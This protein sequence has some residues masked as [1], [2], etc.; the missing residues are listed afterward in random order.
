MKRPAY[1]VKTK[2]SKKT[3]Q[4]GTRKKVKSP[5]QK[6]PS[7]E[8]SIQPKR[9]LNREI[10][11]LRFNERVLAQASDSRW[12]LLERVKFLSIYTSN[13]DEFFMKRV[14]GLKRQ[15][16]FGVSSKSRDG[17]TA[18]QQLNL[19]PQIVR[20]QILDQANI[21]KKEILPELSKNGIFLLRWSQLTVRE[22]S[23]A[24][25]YYQK[26]VFPILTPLAV[27]PGHPFPFIS[28]LSISLGITLKHPE[29]NERLFARVKVP[30]VLPQWV[31]VEE[32]RFVSL[33]AIIQENLNDLFPEMDVLNVMPFRLTRNADVT[34][35]EEGAEDLLELIEE[36]L[37]LRRFA[38]VVRLEHGP[39]PDAWMLDFLVNE[40]KIGSGDV[41]ELPAELDFT[42]LNL[43]ADLQV[44]SLRFKPHNAVVPL[45]FQTDDPNVFFEGIRNRDLLVHHPYE[46]FAQT[47]EKFIRIS[48]EDPKVLA[49]KMTLYRTGDNS[50][51]IKALIAA[52]E[53][54]KQVVC[55]VELKARFDEER[56]I[57]WAQAL[58]NSGVH[59]VYGIVGFKTHAKTALVVRK[60]DEG[61]KSYVHIGTGNYNSS[62]SKIYT[63]LGL[64]TAKPEIT[65]EVVEFFH[66]LTGRSRKRDYKYLLIAP[67]NMFQ[68]FIDAIRK[69]VAH[70]KAGRPAEI[71]CKMNSLEE[72]SLSDELFMASQAGV[73]VR[74]I[75]RG[76]CGF[77][78]GVKGL[79]ENIEV[80]SI[81]G[82]FLEHSR[83]FYFRNGSEDSVDGMFYF[84]SADWMGRNLH[85]RVEAITPVL[86]PDLKMRLWH[87]LD[88]CLVEQRLAWRLLEDGTYKRVNPH[89]NE[90]TVHEKLIDWTRED[91]EQ[92]MRKIK[93]NAADSESE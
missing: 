70:A 63:D 85:A 83:I 66:Y 71:I 30:Q 31:Q 58:E 81:I 9:F 76:F 14:G 6:R 67:V 87:L 2:N 27:D 56:N 39:N 64:F 77:R 65:S 10:G 54:G 55:L 41:Y 22:K 72:G 19:I 84:G 59:V 15:V 73:K 1:P 17:L 62:T 35:D 53:S 12:P 4:V 25:E 16:A 40:L 48:A 13:L 11:W 28:N 50:P 38:E 86:D 49:I 37:R 43:I 36:E 47:V 79:S 69:E 80:T 89:A 23:L 88:Y 61:L 29:H 18:Q 51:F 34:R 82:R 42:G 91:Y 8:I 75:V 44:A 74:L 90:K 3:S 5:H 68:S 57:F 7:P 93:V 20:S 21:Y 78:P 46:S 60:E 92:Q 26:N 52:A 32:N 33:I 45:A 24:H